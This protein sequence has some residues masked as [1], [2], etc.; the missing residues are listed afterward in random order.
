MSIKEE[1]EMNRTKSIKIIMFFWIIFFLFFLTA[2]GNH[3]NLKVG[4]DH[5]FKPFG[6]MEQGT[7]KGF[8]VDLWKAVAQEAGFTYEIIPMPA[9]EIMQSLQ[10]GKIDAGLAGFTIKG[11]RKKQID[12][13]TP[14]F[15]TG[16]VILVTTDN[17]K[18]KSTKELEDKVVATRVGST[19]YEYVSKIKGIKEVRGFPDITQAYKE[20]VNKK[21]DAVVFDSPNVFDYVQTEGKGKVKTV[22][23]LLTNEQYGIALKKGSP[24]R[25]R[26][27]NALRELGKNGTYEEIYVKWFGHKPKSVPGQSS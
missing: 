14:Y 9:G 19:G 3:G 1:F 24:Y 26:V 20:L 7:K 11:D 6:F 22:G 16:Q 15:D 23:I 12:F 5:S 4:I 27:N 21:V 2:C 18:V 25:G 13:A 10:K 8:D 17:K